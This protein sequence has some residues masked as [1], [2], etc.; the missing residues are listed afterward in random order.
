MPA[1]HQLPLSRIDASA[2]NSRTRRFE[3]HWA[4]RAAS[5][6]AS[7]WYVMKSSG[8][9][10]ASGAEGACPI[11][12]PVGNPRTLSIGRSSASQ[13]QQCDVCGGRAPR[14]IRSACVPGGE[15]HG[16]TGE[17]RPQRDRCVMPDD[18]VRRPA[19]DRHLELLPA[20]LAGHVSGVRT[21]SRCSPRE[22]RRSSSRS[23][24]RRRAGVGPRWRS[25]AWNGGKA[26]TT[27]PFPARRARRDRPRRH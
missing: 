26:G 21:W 8:V 24:C 11:S 12:G 27:R 23:P 4:H 22:T 9:R 2:R 18:A 3:G 15:K 7:R 6:S 17:H 5:V 25:C 1:I 20:G 19:G 14:L 10:R 16:A 13:Q